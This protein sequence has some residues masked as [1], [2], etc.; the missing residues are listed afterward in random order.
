MFEQAFRNIDDALVGNDLR[1]SIN[2]IA[3]EF[4]SKIFVEFER[5]LIKQF[6]LQEKIECK[7]VGW[8]FNRD[9]SK[10]KLCIQ[11]DALQTHFVTFNLDR[12]FPSSHG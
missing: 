6:H 2:D 5:S 10:N 9:H 7:T 4:A 8:Y 1:D 11:S 3:Y 12:L